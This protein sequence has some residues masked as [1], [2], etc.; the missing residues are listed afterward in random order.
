MKPDDE[1]ITGVRTCRRRSQA[2]LGLGLGFRVKL[3]LGLGFLMMFLFS[4][5]TPT[6]IN[7]TRRE[8]EK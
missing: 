6:L 5:N 8:R 3:G 1:G 2:K 4:N 7:A